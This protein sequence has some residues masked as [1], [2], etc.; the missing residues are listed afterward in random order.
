MVDYE[1]EK[2]KRAVQW[3]VD[4]SY[5]AQTI[6]KVRKAANR[7]RTLPFKDDEA[8][9]NELVIIG[10]QSEEALDKLIALAEFKRD[11][12]NDY[13]RKFMAQ[14][15]ARDRRVIAIEEQVVGK[16]YSVDKR[17]EVLARQYEQWNA[18]RDAHL[19]HCRVDYLN[20]FGT[21]PGWEQRNQFKREFWALKDM[22]LDALAEQANQVAAVQEAP[23]KKR[24]VVVEPKKQD[25]V[26]N[27]TMRSK[28]M[29]LLD[30][31]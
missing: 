18:E 11:S 3:L 20:K 14:K 29:K 12:Y 23:R 1:V 10:R 25:A 26:R 21:E 27:S 24:L 28:L 2:A 8:I 13:Q 5:F 17:R 16:K 15:R 9:L 4:T 22:E 6:A 30:K 7:P 31:K 19:E